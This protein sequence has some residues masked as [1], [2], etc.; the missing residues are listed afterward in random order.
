MTEIRLKTGQAATLK[1]GVAVVAGAAQ[2]HHYRLMVE[3]PDGKSCIATAP[4]IPPLL[5][6]AA[7]MGR[8]GYDL[9]SLERVAGKTAT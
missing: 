5:D 4:T 7:Q 9:L 2:Q 1:D 6:V 3:R 8:M